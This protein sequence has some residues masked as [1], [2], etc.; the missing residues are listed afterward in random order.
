[1]PFRIGEMQTEI[2]VRPAETAPGP[3]AAPP[4]DDFMEIER[5]RPMVLRILREELDRL[6]RQQG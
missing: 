1:M 4:R 2:E 3:G 6:R 5:L